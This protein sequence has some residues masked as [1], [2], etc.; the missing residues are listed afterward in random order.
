MIEKREFLVDHRIPRRQVPTA[1]GPCANQCSVVN[2]AISTCADD[3]CFCPVLTDSGT[4]CSQCYATADITAASD[5]SSAFSICQSEFSSPTSSAA[6]LVSACSVQCSL[7]NQALSACPDDTCFCPAA[8]ASGSQ[9]S[10][11]LATVDIVEAQIIGSA[12]QV[13]QNEFPTTT[14]GFSPPTSNVNTSSPTMFVP[15]ASGPADSA[16]T[17]TPT[18]ASG[19]PTSSS[20]LAPGAI[21]G[22]VGGFIGLLAIGA[23]LMFCF[24]RRYKNRQS[25]QPTYQPTFAEPAAPFTQP[26]PTYPEPE[27]VHGTNVNV[28]ENNAVETEIPSARLRYLDPDE[29]APIL[30]STD[31][32]AEEG[33]LEIIEGFAYL[34]LNCKLLLFGSWLV[35]WLVINYLTDDYR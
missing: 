10:S 3:T 22:I 6:T 9:C 14:T 11:C 20:G 32:G 28:D 25:S 21:G 29:V 5:L 33:L 16:S 24:I 4:P 15:L 23:G 8:L 19:A 2:Q 30:G 1:V 35:G 27:T 18:S 12:I 31:S 26:A 13:C 17:S 34:E 7:I